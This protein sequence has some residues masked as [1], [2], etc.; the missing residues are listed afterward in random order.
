M[1]QSSKPFIQVSL[2]MW[3]HK[4]KGG[5]Q[6]NTDARAKV[7]RMNVGKS[8]KMWCRRSVQ[9]L[10]T[11]FFEN[12]CEVRVALSQNEQVFAQR[13]GWNLAADFS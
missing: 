11:Y 8:T 13:P 9:I 3:D 7:A 4:D 1:R 5:W 12:G 2:L 10:T 6:P